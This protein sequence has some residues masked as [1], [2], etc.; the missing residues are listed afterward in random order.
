MT[1]LLVLQLRTPGGDPPIQ[2]PIKTVW[3]IVLVLQALLMLGLGLAL[4]IAPEQTGS[5]FWPWNLSALTGR[6]IGAW[7]IGIGTTAAHMAYEKDW[8]RV[9]VG[10]L[11]D[12]VFGAMQLITVVRFASDR[13]SA[14]SELVLDWKDPLL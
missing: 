1:I 8:W 11:S 5:I 13:N 4:F 12:W 6:A 3:R 9:E 10:A 2:I 14:T 7:L